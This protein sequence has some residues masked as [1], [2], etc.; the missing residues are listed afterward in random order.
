MTTVNEKMVGKKCKKLAAA[1]M[2]GMKSETSD[3]RAAWL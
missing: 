1:A 2:E 3:D